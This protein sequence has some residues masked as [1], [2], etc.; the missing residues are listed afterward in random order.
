MILALLALAIPVLFVSGQS[1]PQDYRAY[2]DALEA[3][4]LGRHVDVLQS[5]ETVWQFKPESPLK[6][7][8][9]LAA[10]K[11]YVALGRTS[12]GAALLRQ[13]YSA[14]PQPDGDAALAEV[15]EAAGNTPG[16][17]AYWQ[18]VYYGH[19]LSDLAITAEAT[20]DR[21]RVALGDRFPPVMPDV[22]L[23]RAEKLRRAGQSARAK[24]ELLSAVRGFAGLE[25]EL[26][27]VRAHFGD[28][29]ALSAL[30]TSESDAEAER[31]YLM[32]AA[33]RRNSLEPQAEA[34]MRQ[35]EKRFPQSK[36]TMDALI[37]WGNHHLL[38]NNVS[39]YVPLYKNCHERFPADPQAAYCH[40]KTAWAAWINRQTNARALL[41]EHVTRFPDSEKRSA[42]LYFLDRHEEVIRA[43][44]MSWYATLARAKW[45]GPLPKVSPDAAVFNPSAALRSR[46]G[47]ARQ[48]QTA[49]FYDWAEF[50]LKFAASEQPYVAAMEL[51]DTAATRGAHDQALRY[52][53]GIARGYLT[54][55]LEAAPERFWKLAFPMPW[56]SE[57]E[58][59]S[60]DR[61][62][63]PFIVAALI[64]QESEFNPKAVSSARAYGLTQ[65]L[66]STGRSLSRKAGIHGFRPTMLFDPEVNL[67][68]GTLYLRSMLDQHDG[69][70]E[71]TLASY[72]AGKSRTN[73][74]DTWYTYQEPAEFVET[75]PFTE[76]RNYVQ[77]VLR[78]ADVY[79][80]VYSRPLTATARP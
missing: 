1:V 19:P 77:I 48:L 69:Q 57:L 25:R 4:K 8:A 60:R 14:L 24:R 40:W 18:K 12:D 71:R 59:T 56:R 15:L 54:L 47:R 79:R 46:I 49:G 33:A 28:Y 44:P 64:R 2:F 61:G 65:V 73:L 11:S 39:E 70:W 6:G 53:K 23:S 30:K 5:L 31:I 52:I 58:T 78:N 50:E 22:V 7:K 20:L 80:R 32:H 74:W 21:L 38:R 75:I 68:L 26:A 67:K 35:L 37:S 76:T 27:M 42:A 17:A 16:A 10:A 36:W 3:Q 51:A 41:E 66:P 62:I 34:A 55:P 63:E 43:H 45:K 72:N 9:A 29:R 13:Q